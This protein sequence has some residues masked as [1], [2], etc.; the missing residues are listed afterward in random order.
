LE[1]KVGAFF[2]AMFSRSKTV[3]QETAHK[4]V[5]GHMSLLA[6]WALRHAGVIGAMLA[7]GKGGVDVGA[8]A[9]R[10]NMSPEVLFS[11]LEY[12]AS[13]GLAT[14]TEGR[15]TLS[16]MGRALREHEDGVLEMVRAYQP[17]LSA[18]EHLLARLK[19]YGGNISRKPEA[20]LESQTV[21]YAADVYPALEKAILKS[22]A[23]HVLDL[24]CGTGELLIRL[25]KATKNLAGVGV[26]GDGLS[27]RKA[28]E[29]VTRAGF[30]KRFIAVAGTPMDVCM[31]TREAFERLGISTA[32]WESVDC[33]VATGVFGELAGRDSATVIAALARIP[34]IFPNAAVILA[35]ACDDPKRD[36]TYYAA[37]MNLLLGITR[38]MLLPVQQW[39]DM[40]KVAGLRIAGETALATD[41]LTL[42]MCEPVGAAVRKAKGAKAAI[43]PA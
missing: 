1:L 18:V 41:A 6:Y 25:G 7:E 31:E 43:S 35:E 8:F 14:V 21:R 9:A 32:F 26:G 4:L 20:L 36:E 2:M 17:V 30:E 19:T 40:L 37:E 11:L 13:T 24:N 33:V 27:V 16:A 5:S 39:R 10:T 22:G 28:N 29:A 38:H 42:F 15:A 3:A 12:L 34:R 23:T